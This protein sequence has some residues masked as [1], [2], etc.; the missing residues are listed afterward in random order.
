MDSLLDRLV[1]IDGM[2]DDPISLGEFM[3]INEF[4]PEEQAEIIESLTKTGSFT[5]GGGAAAEY[6][7]RLQA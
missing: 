2:T 4:E 1:V 7:I 5:G 6:T 3:E